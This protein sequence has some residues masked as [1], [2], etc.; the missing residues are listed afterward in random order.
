[1]NYIKLTIFLLILIIIALCSYLISLIIKLDDDSSRF[2]NYVIL[3]CV[4]LY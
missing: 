3:S 1:M 2:T 4:I